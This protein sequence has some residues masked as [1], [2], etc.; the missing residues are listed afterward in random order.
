LGRAGAGER[1]AEPRE[2]ARGWACDLPAARARSGGCGGHRRGCCSAE[3][4]AIPAAWARR[5]SSGTGLLFR[6]V[7]HVG[8]GQVGC[9]RAVL[10][11]SFLFHGEAQKRWETA[12]LRA[13]SAKQP[14]RDLRAALLPG[15]TIHPPVTPYSLPSTQT[16]FASNWKFDIFTP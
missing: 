11:P 6:S 2:P 7:S 10:L 9:C 3:P 12:I 8:G 16:G 14:L 1:P 13:K 15:T 5:P 4:C